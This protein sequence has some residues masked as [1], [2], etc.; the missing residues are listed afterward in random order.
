MIVHKS[1]LGNDSFMMFHV[2]ICGSSIS[3]KPF[4][5]AVV[6]NLTPSPWISCIPWQAFCEQRRPPWVWFWGP[7]VAVAN[8]GLFGHGEKTQCFWN[9]EEE[10]RIRECGFVLDMI[11]ELIFKQSGQA[12]MSGVFFFVWCC[13]WDFTK[14]SWDCFLGALWT[15]SFIRCFFLQPDIFSEDSWC[16]ETKVLRLFVDREWSLQ[17]GRSFCFCLDRSFKAPFSPLRHKRRVLADRNGRGWAGMVSLRVPLQ[18][19]CSNCVQLQ[20]YYARARTICSRAHFVCFLLLLFRCLCEYYLS[21]KY[22]N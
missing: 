2:Q 14:I 10:T 8:E 6:G 18:V 11:L 17:T 3:L 4:T 20:S 22:S 5:S 12:I 7:G 9:V 16:D 19:L 13:S 15:S 21:L 1:L